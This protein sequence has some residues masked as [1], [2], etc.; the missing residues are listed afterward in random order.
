[1]RPDGRNKK[2]TSIRDLVGINERMDEALIFR[3]LLSNLYQK[4]ECIVLGHE[5]MLKFVR[6]KVPATNF[7]EYDYG[8][9]F[10]FFLSWI[11]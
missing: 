8:S 4:M 1:M 7:I 11:V 3:E 6:A 2:T 9:L 10:L 5:L